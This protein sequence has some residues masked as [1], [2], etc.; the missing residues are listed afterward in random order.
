MQQWKR[1]RVGSH[2]KY[3]GICVKRGENVKILT[4]NDEK[5]LADVFAIAIA[6]SWY[7]DGHD[8]GTYCDRVID[9]M[10][11][12][13]K[14]QYGPE[15]LDLSERYG[16]ESIEI[17]VA[18]HAKN[19]IPIE[20]IVNIANNLRKKGDED[21]AGVLETLVDWWKKGEKNELDN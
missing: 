15:I 5:D 2:G 7:L 16:L 21:A 4:R 12:I 1:G 8:S 19:N 10:T 20:S 17:D 9:V 3:S 6:G 13:M 18:Y 14:F 11:K